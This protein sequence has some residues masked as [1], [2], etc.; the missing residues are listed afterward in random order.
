MT[1]TWTISVATGSNA[2]QTS[3]GQAGGNAAGG[4]EAKVEATISAVA[5]EAQI[6]SYK[7]VLILEYILCTV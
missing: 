2:I 5:L 3:G 7:L 4:A 1:S 6:S